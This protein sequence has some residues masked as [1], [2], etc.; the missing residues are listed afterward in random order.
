MSEVEF[1]EEQA[2]I[3][4][5]TGG[6]TERPVGTRGLFGLIIRTG[7]AK[8]ETGALLVLSVAG[9]IALVLAFG[10]FFVALS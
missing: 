7:L 8:D 9:V 6:P 1:P 2:F 3:K 4:A 5:S 10:I